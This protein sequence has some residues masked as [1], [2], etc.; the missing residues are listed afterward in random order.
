[1]SSRTWMIFDVE[2]IGLHGEAFAVAYVVIEE[3]NGH[4][5]EVEHM[6]IWCDPENAAGDV[7]GMK[8]VS[9]HVPVNSWMHKE[10]KQHCRGVEAVAESVWGRCVE[11]KDKG[12]GLCADVSWPCRLIP[13]G[14]AE[15]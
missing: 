8:W 5:Q 14:A 15:E 1:M 4:W 10:G 7:A 3:V 11:R 13:T 6:L 9:Q 2:S 12:A